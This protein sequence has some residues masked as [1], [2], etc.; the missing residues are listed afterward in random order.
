[1]SDEPR[2]I[3]VGGFLG[4]GK[5]TAILQFA[6]WLFKTRN[7]KV[8]LITND[9]ANGLV[10]TAITA[11]AQFAVREI[12]GGCFCCQSGSLVDAMQQFSSELR[13]EVLIGEPVGSCT[14]LASTVLGPLRSVYNCPYLL[15]PLSVLI[16]PF[17][18]ER[19]LFLQTSSKSRFSNEVDYIYRKQVEEAEII[20]IN[21]CDV[22]PEKRLQALM[23]KTK[24]CYP[25]AEVFQVSART[26]VGLE[27]WWE[28]ILTMTHAADGYMDVDY[29]VYAD[30]EARLGWLNAEY[31]LDT[32]GAGQ[33]FDGNR[34]LER[35][36]SSIQQAFVTLGIEVAHLKL[37]LESSDYEQSGKERALAVMQWVRS[38][39]Q[40]EFTLRLDALQSR[41]TLLLN[42]RAE[43][44][45]ERLADVVSYS[46]K[47]VESEA[48]FRCVNSS[49]FS[50][51]AP[52]PTHRLSSQHVGQS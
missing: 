3:M 46:F 37:S 36:V 29:S 5:T 16:D 43:A 27:E 31:E 42:L 4:A 19:S 48:R 35:L 11:S 7:W 13:P 12:G 23:E 22:V 34:I 45:P 44:E 40:P 52:K 32:L 30:G 6:R 41:A 15:A 49:A 51:S 50:P 1:M 33:K 25:N 10:D 39:A 38:D 20:A 24:A 9:Q 21:K 14:D 18:A 8:G 17:R 2:F 26:G 28:R 47:A